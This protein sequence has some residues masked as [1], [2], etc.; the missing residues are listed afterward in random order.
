[1][2]VRVKRPEEM[3]ITVGLLAV[4]FAE[5]MQLPSGYV[6]VLKFLIK[7]YLI[8]RRTS[9]PHMA[10][11]TGFYRGMVEGREEQK[12]QLAGTVEICFN[13]R[14]AY[15]SPHQRLPGIRHTYVTWL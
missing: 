8:E 9:M 5:S 3:D 2:L 12:V 7:Q 1:M 6:S 10:T 15:S 11:L 4:S 13:K 14:G